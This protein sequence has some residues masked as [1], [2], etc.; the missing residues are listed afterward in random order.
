MIYSEQEKELIELILGIRNISD[1]KSTLQLALESARFHCGIE[2]NGEIDNATFNL[3]QDFLERIYKGDFKHYISDEADIFSALLSYLICLEQIGTIFY[4]KDKINEKE[5]NGI[6][7][8]IN[9]FSPGLSQKERIALKN[10]RNSLGHTFGLV[11]LDHHKKG[12]HKFNLNFHEESKDVIKVPS[13]KNIWDGDYLEKSERTDTIVYVYPL[14]RFIEKTIQ[15]VIGE[16]YKGNLRFIDY[17]EIKSR[18]T[19]LI[20]SN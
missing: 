10:L 17:E 16:Y 13:E 20:K 3:R 15:N 5:S 12:T 8:A 9:F 1:R 4:I 14:I 19:I 6:V 2:K 7:N 11:N 18:F